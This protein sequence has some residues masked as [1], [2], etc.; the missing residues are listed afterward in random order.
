MAILFMDQETHSTLV[1][2]CKHQGSGNIWGRMA[3]H[4]QQIEG[5]GIF[6]DT[7]EEDADPAVG[8]VDELGFPSV[9]A[10]C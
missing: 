8:L 3:S 6:S 5:K 4:G 7:S 9:T 2:R 1:G 10:M